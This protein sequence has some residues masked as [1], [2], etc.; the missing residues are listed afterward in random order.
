MKKALLLAASVAFIAPQAFAQ[1]KSFEGFSVGA[2][3][4]VAKSTTEPTGVASD[5]GNTT[6]LDLQAQYSLALAPQV[7]LGLGLT[8]G[9]G[10]NKAG[11]FTTGQEFVTKNRMAFDIVPG[12]AISSNMMLFGKVSSLS[13]DGAFTLAGVE[14][15][16]SLSGVGYGF[17]LRGLIDKNMFYQVGY[18]INKYNDVDYGGGSVKESSSV[19]SL[20]VGYKF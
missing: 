14:T 8:L 17:G 2:N 7:V 13:A 5:S 1:A 16:K 15:K 19:F 6:S 3:L 11:T 18:D 9:T 10:N 4:A 20:G 12:Y